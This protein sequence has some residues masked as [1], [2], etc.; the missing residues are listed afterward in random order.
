MKIKC[1]FISMLIV[2]SLCLSCLNIW[3]NASDNYTQKS[4]SDIKYGGTVEELPEY[5]Y[6][7]YKANKKAESLDIY[8]QNLF[9]VTTN[10][11][12]GTKT[13]ELYQTP[14]KYIEEDEIKFIDISIKSTSIL[15]QLVSEYFY[16]CETTPVKSFYPKQISDGISVENG[17]YSVECSPNITDEYSNKLFSRPTLSGKD[18]VL[19]YS[20]FG[21]SVDISY[22]P[23]SNGVKEEIILNECPDRNIF[24][25]KI[26]LENLQPVYLTG[27]SIPL[28][29][30]ETGEQVAAISQ[31]DMRDSASATTYNTS[32]FNH[33]ELEL[34][35]DSTY[36]LRIILDDNFLKATT[37]V[38]P[39]IVDPTITFNADPIYDAPVFS[40]YPSTN[41]NSNT[42]NVVGYHGSTYGEGIGFVKINNIQN[43]LYIRP[44][45][46]T[47][48]YLKVYESSG[49]TS[50]AKIGVYNTKATWSNTSITYNNKPSLNAEPYSTLTV[51]NSG[52]YNFDISGFIRN[53]LRFALNEGGKSQ[54]YGLALKMLDT[55]VSSRHFCSANHSSYPPSIIINY[56]EYTGLEEG[57]YIIRSQYH[58]EAKPYCYL[59]ASGSNVIQYTAKGNANQIWKVDYIGNGYYEIYSTANT[60]MAM[61]VALSEPGNATNVGLYDSSA[62]NRRKFRIIKN[63][64]GS[65]RILSICGNKNKGLDVCG[66]SNVAGTNI[67]SWEYSGVTQQQWNFYKAAPCGYLNY[68]YSDATQISHL[69]NNQ[70]KIFVDKTAGFGKTINTL[71]TYADYALESWRDLGY[72]YTF[73]DSADE[74]NI[75]LRGITRNEA[76]SIDEGFGQAEGF[77][78]NIGYNG[79]TATYEGQA[80]SSAGWKSV[81][82]TT[83]RS[84][85]IVWDTNGN[86][87]TAKTSNNSALK[88]KAVVA[89]ELGH[90]LGYEGHDTSVRSIMF[91]SV[92]SIYKDPINVTGPQERDF[93]H[94]KQVY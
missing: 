13:V 73:V 8:D 9:S 40:G 78:I 60:S 26:D 61:G 32:L 20:V 93:L 83:K 6:E 91:T 46:I 88:W 90:A 54:G 69:K 36:I 30:K 45:N 2:F 27:D 79:T 87:G 29:D 47:S 11:N 3:V 7:S 82:T 64:D 59:Y 4:V 63:A 65:Y 42:Y 53:W 19:Y 48:A 77:C 50:T 31:I 92:D 74:C 70:I 72:S 58:P 17:K 76:L 62:G 23:I 33:I 75:H 44:E 38:Y 24:E 18:K 84:V 89:H 25:F 71:I 51:T 86:D 94:L 14:I 52:W 21:E 22:S 37:T 55:G 85:Y 68:W 34:I 66:P 39:V 12:D 16:K 57:N 56:T 43:Y 1:K 15:E 80:L 81:Y 35:E 41:F 10:N 49:K 5:I 28:R 67:Q